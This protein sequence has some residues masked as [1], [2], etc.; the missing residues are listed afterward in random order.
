MSKRHYEDG[1]YAL[2]AP[3][4]SKRGRLPNGINRISTLSDETLLHILSFL[5]IS[6]LIVCQRLSYRFNALAQD[7]ELWKRHYYYRWVRQPRRYAN[8]RQ[9]V[10]PVVEYSPKVSSWLNHSH[11]ANAGIRMD[12]KGQYRLRH[13]WSRGV[14]RVTEVELSQPYLRPALIAFCAGVIFTVDHDS[15]L[16]ARST[17]SPAFCLAEISLTCPRAHP[18][19]LPTAVTAMN[20]SRPNLIEIAVGF[21]DGHFGI[22][23]MD[24]TSSPLRICFN[25]AGSTNGAITAMS[26]LYPYLLLVSHHKVLSLFRLGTDF[27]VPVHL[28]PREPTL[29]SSLEADSIMEP[30]SLSVRSAGSDVITSI[31]YSFYHAGCGWSLGIQESLF[32]CSTGLQKETRLTTTVDSQYGI[33]TPLAH[34]CSGTD[35]SC[36]WVE[37]NRKNTSRLRPAEP[38][39]H[40][41]EAPTSVSY[42]HPYLL[43]SHTDNTLTVYLV[44]STSAGLCIKGAQRLWGH[45]SSVSAVQVNER[46]KAISVSSQGDEIR[47]WELEGLVSAFGRQRAR[48]HGNSIRICPGKKQSDISDLTPSSRAKDNS[49]P[50]TTQGPHSITK[51]SDCIRFDDERVLLLRGKKIDGQM[52][53]SYDFT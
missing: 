23:N 32:S 36:S 27:S 46:G 35:Q 11:L 24:T 8:S 29:L 43:S 21:E 34:S 20:G 12:W 5:P 2:H 3:R 14:C 48:R 53:K 1:L 45:T 7:S 47:V 22:Y 4:P 6:S 49:L 16:R 33:C 9:T 37:T 44:M 18:A 41:Q 15:Q 25:S 10:L 50:N 19:A 42:S 13:N 52:L 26:S 31:V 38:S 39:I 51:I 30:M 17:Q 40:H 28:L